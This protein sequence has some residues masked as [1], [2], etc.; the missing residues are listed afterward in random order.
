[1]LHQILSQVMVLE[2]IIIWPNVENI[3]QVLHEIFRVNFMFGPMLVE[4]LDEM[5]NV[6]PFHRLLVIISKGVK[7]PLKIKPCKP[8]FAITKFHVQLMVIT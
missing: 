6:G 7:F 1:M 8:L 3:E 4:V 5:L 2:Q